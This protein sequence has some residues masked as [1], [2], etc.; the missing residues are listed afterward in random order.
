MSNKLDKYFKKVFENEHFECKEEYFLQME[1]LGSKYKGKT[2]IRRSVVLLSLLVVGIIAFI[3]LFSITKSLNTQQSEVILKGIVNDENTQSHDEKWSANKLQSEQKLSSGSKM[4]LIEII[5]TNNLEVGNV[6]SSA[7]ATLNVVEYNNQ[8]I[9][10]WNSN[11]FIIKSEKNGK[12]KET[13]TGSDSSHAQLV[14]T[15][16][17]DLLTNDSNAYIDSFK[18]TE[19]NRS[20]GLKDADLINDQKTTKTPVDTVANQKRAK[21]KPSMSLNT[22]FVQGSDSA[23]YPLGLSDNADSLQAGDSTSIIKYMELQS[24]D[25]LA[26]DS[27]MTLLSDSI[28]NIENDLVYPESTNK[29]YWLLGAEVGL[30]SISKSPFRNVD[31]HLIDS[32]IGNESFGLGRR[33]GLNA[34]SIKGMFC[35]SF[36]LSF[37]TIH[38]N[39]N[40]SGEQI[41]YTYDTSYTLV[42]PDYRG[43]GAAVWLI[44]RQVD[45]F[46]HTIINNDISGHKQN[47]FR[48]LEIPLSIGFHYSWWQIDLKA[49]AGFSMLY[50][51]K[52]RGFYLNEEGSQLVEI[53]NYGNSLA[54]F[55]MVGLNISYPIASKLRLYCSGYYKTPYY[56]L[57]LDPNFGWK[58]I[59]FN[60]GINFKL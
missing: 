22:G 50:A 28:S 46:E 40:Y 54:I 38:E 13:L 6:V 8:K 11:K 2:G 60:A 30:N 32:R 7:D 5:D 58:Q 55:P 12:A 19:K 18:G 47:I 33:F 26:K 57:S 15:F 39:L 10:K 49:M 29:S 17:T 36:G 51:P 43:A 16:Y 53:R 1:S 31:N 52:P 4:H 23:N 41:N 34:T 45:S 59:T 25:S 9:D 3:S 14:H 37:G 35:Y 20:F 27:G 44:H 21:E 56:K 48:Y 24:A 42:N